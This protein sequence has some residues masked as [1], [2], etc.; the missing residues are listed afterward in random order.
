MLELPDWGYW[1][2][3]KTVTLRDALVLSTGL[4][5]HKYNHENT[6]EIE[7]EYAQKYWDN[8]QIA[9]NHVYENDWVVGKVVRED[10]DVDVAQTSV[11]FE[12]FCQWAYLTVQLSELPTEMQILGMAVCSELADTTDK[13]CEIESAFSSGQVGS[14]DTDSLII[15]EHLDTSVLATPA[16]LLGA[17]GQWGLKKG[18]FNEPSKHTW[19][20]AARK[21]RGKGSNK[22]IPPLYCPYE[23]MIGLNTKIRPRN[24]GVRPSLEKGF[25]HLGRFFPAVYTK[26]EYMA[27]DNDQS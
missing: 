26:F 6:N 8:L 5:P 18:W 1:G 7:L 20:L 14:P 12:K 24:G 10:F 13:P 9:K 25:E 3:L 11:N 15:P 2:R 22:P 4:C 19:L 27:P 23:V 16:Q 21:Q 17:F